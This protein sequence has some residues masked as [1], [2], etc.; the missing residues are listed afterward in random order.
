M[1]IVIIII[2]V[3]YG[4]MAAVWLVI[5]HNVVVGRDKL[6]VNISCH[7]L[8]FCLTKSDLTADSGF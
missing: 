2:G 5:L 6:K 8:Q 4:D 1:G 7:N 3:N